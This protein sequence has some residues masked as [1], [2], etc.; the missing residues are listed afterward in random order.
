MREEEVDGEMIA[1]DARRGSAK[2]DLLFLPLVLGCRVFAIDPA[3]GEKGD[4]T[5]DGKKQQKYD[6]DSD[7]E[8][9]TFFKVIEPSREDVPASEEN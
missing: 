9:I 3:F 2:S 7:C 6:K 4:N 1:T 5:Y 8:G